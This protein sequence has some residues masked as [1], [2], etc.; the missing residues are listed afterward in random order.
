[1][2]AIESILQKLAAA[3]QRGEDKRV[4]L[5]LVDELRMAVLDMPLILKPEML[6]KLEAPPQRALATSTETAAARID[7]PLRVPTSSEERPVPFGQPLRAPMPPRRVV[8]EEEDT[9]LTTS[10]AAAAADAAPV[11]TVV[12]EFVRAQLSRLPSDHH[13]FVPAPAAVHE[14][15][16][17]PVTDEMLEEVA[18]INGRGKQAA[19]SGESVA[20]ESATVENK[21]QP[22][23]IGKRAELHEVLA[24]QP[25]TTLNERFV[26]SVPAVAELVATPPIT[27]LRKAISVADKFQYLNELFRR[28]ESL[29]ERSIKTINGF[30]NYGEAEHW[31]RRE[32][33]TR[34]GWDEKSELVQQ[35]YAVVRR[36]FN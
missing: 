16:E 32:L 22:Q 9:P 12:D 3:T 8:V 29:F 18:A 20:D 35:F 34:L 4:L 24:N 25:A 1:M 10:Q 30:N 36:R 14:V 2:T 21:L 11:A 5:Q 13:A 6:E 31:I 7:A 26:Q 33:A 17:L 15:L 27:D 28:D 19:A 23:P